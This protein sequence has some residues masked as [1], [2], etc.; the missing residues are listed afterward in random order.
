MDRYLYG[1]ALCLVIGALFVWAEEHA[2]RQECERHGG[3]RR[4]GP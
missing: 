2:K 1:L 3:R 4:Y